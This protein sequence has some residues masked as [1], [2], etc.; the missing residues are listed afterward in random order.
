MASGR[1][2]FYC[3]SLSWG[4]LEMN[5][6]KYAGLLMENNYQI[7]IYCVEES[8]IAQK[9]KTNNQNA[10]YVARNNKYYDLINAYKVYRLMKKDLIK[11]VWIRDNRDLS[12]IGLVK[13]LSRDNIQIIYQQGMQISIKKN[14]VLHTIRF[15]KIDAWI[16]PL[17][18][19][20]S[21]LKINTNFNQE[22]IFVIPLMVE[23]QQNENMVSKNQAR[24]KFELSKGTFVI[25]ILGR[26]SLLKGQLFLIKELAKLRNQNFDIEL[27]IVG[28]KSINEGPEY[29]NN[30]EKSIKRLNLSQF[31]KI[32]PYI[33][34]VEVFY[35]SIDLFVMASRG[36]TYGNV[37]VE[38]MCHG[39][40]VLGT[41]SSGTP[42]LLGFGEYGYLYR[43]DDE[44]DFEQNVKWILGNYENAKEKALKAQKFAFKNYNK[45][46][47]FDQIERVLSV[48]NLVKYKL[49]TKT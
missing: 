44:N 36:E 49:I 23:M 25:G 47:I 22:K 18:F 2:G 39:V 5:F 8:P 13:T 12:L 28:E 27:L 7:K 45:K 6:V 11:A 19:L 26:I 31:V 20:N 37:T 14:D 30:L 43:A 24:E 42:E 4:G 40:P 48:L 33:E 3:S 35:Q 17:N 34:D 9:L 1:I 32:H 15:S 46:I 16:T 38:A 29:L 41:K 21:Q 10:T